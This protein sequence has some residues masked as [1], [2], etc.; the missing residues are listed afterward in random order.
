VYV[1]VLISKEN[2]GR[3]LHVVCLHVH[4][5]AITVVPRVYTYYV[6]S[7]LFAVFGLKMLRDGWRMSPTEAM[8]E[9]EEV[10]EDLR[11][12]E[13]EQDLPN[14]DPEAGVALVAGATSKPSPVHSLLGMFV[15]HI[16]LQ[17]SC[18]HIGP[19]VSISF[20]RHLR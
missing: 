13:R 1:F 10:Q 7:F 16:F 2:G 15:S 18:S 12:R 14:G 11:K 20:P 19:S 9:M 17:V 8:E 4:R 6:S 3:I 5:Y